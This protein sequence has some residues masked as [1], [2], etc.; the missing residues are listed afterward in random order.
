MQL[1][2]TLRAFLFFYFSPMNVGTENSLNIEKP[3]KYKS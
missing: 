2:A 3:F 1:W